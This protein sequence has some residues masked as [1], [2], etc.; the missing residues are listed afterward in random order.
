A[1][2]FEPGCREFESLRAGHLCVTRYLVLPTREL[3]IG[4]I[5]G[6]NAPSIHPILGFAG[7]V[8][9]KPNRVDILRA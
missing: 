7:L 1:P 8:L 9:A 4:L 5:E 2:G 6:L 3:A